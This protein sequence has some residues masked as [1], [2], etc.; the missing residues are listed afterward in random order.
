MK[1]LFKVIAAAVALA[2]PIAATST[3]ALAA[4]LAQSIIINVKITL[5]VSGNTLKYAYETHCSSMVSRLTTPT[6]TR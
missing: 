3:P 2:A 4:N 6:R 1:S 5:A